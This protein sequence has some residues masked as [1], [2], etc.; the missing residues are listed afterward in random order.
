MIGC[1]SVV[2]LV[3]FQSLFP[4]ALTMLP[5]TPRR[6]CVMISKPC[7]QLLNIHR[8]WYLGGDGSREFTSHGK[9]CLFIYYIF[10]SVRS[11]SSFTWRLWARIGN[12]SRIWC[13]RSS[14][15]SVVAAVCVWALPCRGFKEKIP[16]TAMSPC[17][18]SQVGRRECS[19]CCLC[20][21]TSERS[22]EWWSGVWRREVFPSSEFFIPFLRQVPS[23]F[24]VFPFWDSQAD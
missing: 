19:F 16:W 6:M 7:L 9:L 2:C 20:C 13:V 4:P 18:F 21:F 12:T 1:S 15:P 5:L 14:H 24:C 10:L 17:C 3:L 8:L 23:G 11:C 22:R